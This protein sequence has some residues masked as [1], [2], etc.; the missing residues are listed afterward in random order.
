MQGLKEVS[1]VLNHS[2]ERLRTNLPHPDVQCLTKLRCLAEELP[3]PLQ[4]VR[5]QEED[6]AHQCRNGYLQRVDNLQWPEFMKAGHM[7]EGTDPLEGWRQAQQ[8]RQAARVEPWR[9]GRQRQSNNGQEAEQAWWTETNGAR[10]STGSALVSPEGVEDLR[11]MLN[12]DGGEKGPPHKAHR[13][14]GR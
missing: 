14:V 9:Q 5:T 11:T 13:K 2:D 8:A 12:D 7:R 1:G 4:V 3:R 10:S 6:K